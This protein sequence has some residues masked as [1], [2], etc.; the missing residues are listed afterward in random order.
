MKYLI[1]KT[2]HCDFKTIGVNRLEPRAYFIAHSKK[3]NAEK[4]LYNFERYKSD[5][6]TVLSGEWDFKYYKKKSK[7]PEKLD[8]DKIKFDKIS[9][10]STWQRTG[11]DSPAYINCPYTFD[12]V[13]LGLPEKQGVK[14]PELPEDFSCGV[15][16]KNITIKDIN[17][18]FIITFLGVAA[19]LDLYVNGEFV[20]YGEGSHNSYEFDITKYLKEG[21][22]EIL[23]V[24]FR[25]SNGSYLEAQDMFREN[26]IFRDVLLHT[27]NKAYIN[28]YEA[29]SVKKGGKYNLSVKAEV[30]GDLKNKKIEVALTDGEKVIATEIVDAKKTTELVFKNLDVEEWSAEIPKLYELY[31]TLLDGEKE[32]MTLRSYHGFKTIEIKNAVFYFNGK[33]VKL[34]GVNHH[35]THE[36]KGYALNGDDL[37][38]DVLLMKDYNVNCVRTSHYPPDPYFLELCDHYGL[39]VVDEADI[40]THGLFHL[41][42]EGDAISNDIKWAKHYMDRVRRMYY[43]DRNHASVTMWS[44]GNEAEGYK[45]Q[46]KCYKMLK[47]T[48]TSIPVHY[49]SVCR[50]KRYHYDVFSEMYTHPDD[51]I[52]VREG[53]RGKQYKE[54]PFY[55]CEYAHAMGMGPGSLED[56]FQIFMSDDI[57]MGGCI[58]EWADHSVKHDKSKDGFKYEYTYGGDHG[59]KLHDGC[60]CVDGLFYPDRTP[61]TGAMEMKNVYRPL[62]VKKFS[63][64]KLTVTN[65]NR[66]KS[67]EGI[68]IYWE[69]QENGVNAS[70]GSFMTEIEALKDATYT[71]DLPKIN[72]DKNVYLNITYLENDYEVAK[73]QI[74]LNKADFDL[75]LLTSGKVAITSD[76]EL[77][78]VKFENGSVVFS[79]ETGEMLSYKKDGVSILN[80]APVSHKG[81]MLNLARA[82]TDNDAQTLEMWQRE[83]LANPK[84]EVNDISAEVKSGI[85]I[86]SEYITVYGE[87]YPIF[88]A[89]LIYIIGGNGVI[90]IEV[91]V[92]R[93]EEGAKVLES[94]PRIGL[95][96]ELDKRFNQFEYFGRGELECLCD[97]KA[98]SYIG[99]Y[100]SSVADSH[101]PYIR[102]QDNSNHCDT[103][104]VKLRSDKGEEVLIYSDREFTFN[105]HNYSQ[106]TLLKGNHRED[107][108]NENTTF[109]TLDGFTRGTGSGSCGPETLP[110]YTIDLSKELTFNFVIVVNKDE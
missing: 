36:T 94:V 17:K 21:E 6:V 106:E 65:T 13:Y 48:G 96:V 50:T 87:K 73:E 8:T 25:W 67:S 108:V 64:N 22:N 18:N 12:P 76:E 44:L 42:C 107:V 37:L 92:K 68:E 90:D 14:P 63:N 15:Y 55:L 9:V 100:N 79:E 31:L 11:Y 82:Y 10:P 2:N 78:T 97:Y 99:L 62:R 59:E 19:S 66:F 54:V 72:K 75:P 84:I 81:F 74:E 26:G 101:E 29:V 49:E 103:K 61:H 71:L 51:L 83:N 77:I 7:L 85:A 52:K 104:Y 53:K 60:F 58:W 27:Y 98:Q 20:G 16:R 70:C 88:D 30:K 110:Q 1:N 46:D 34:K 91:A 32:V 3:S 43:R 4:Y 109:V 86:V 45:C 38:K 24:V 5:M 40:E 35:D 80:K 39:Y 95:T 56:Y 23:A 105:I 41:G 57:F 33:K 102:P 93:T 89:Q 47:E 28:D 69:L